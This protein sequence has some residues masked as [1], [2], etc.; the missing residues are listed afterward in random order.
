MFRHNAWHVE[1]VNRAFL[2]SVVPIL[3]HLGTWWPWRDCLSQEWSILSYYKW[4]SFQHS[5][6]MKTDQSRVTWPLPPLFGYGTQGF[7]SQVLIASE[8]ASINWGQPLCLRACWNYSDQPILNLFTLL[9]S[10]F[11]TETTVKAFT[12]VSLCSLWHLTSSVESVCPHPHHWSTLPTL[13]NCNKLSFNG[14]HLLI[15]WPQ[16]SWIR[17]PTF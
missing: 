3:W 17:K 14:S 5:F 1:C 13:G 4:L 8:P 9:P 15:C 11:P 10:L 12:H 7:Y 16:P 2:F 6:H